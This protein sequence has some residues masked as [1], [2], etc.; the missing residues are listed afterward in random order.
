MN[1]KLIPLITHLGGLPLVGYG[2][3]YALNTPGL[4]PTTQGVLLALCGALAG[5]LG[6]KLAG[7][8]PS[9]SEAVEPA[10]GDKT[11]ADGNRGGELPQPV[12][13]PK[14]E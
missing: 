1:P 5:V 7:I 8:L 6:M 12:Q 9:D 11:P 10:Q 3:C 14:A 13:P 2:L 4:T